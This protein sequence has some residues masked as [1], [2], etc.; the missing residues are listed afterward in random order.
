VDDQAIKKYFP[1]EVVTAGLLEI[2]Q[3][4]L[5]FRFE[6]VKDRSESAGWHPEV[7]LFRV[8]DKDTDKLRGYFY[9]DLHPSA[10]HFLM[11]PSERYA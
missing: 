10:T 2:Y 11:R 4:A 8:K 1:L 7:Q 3:R 6:E 9:L 5:A